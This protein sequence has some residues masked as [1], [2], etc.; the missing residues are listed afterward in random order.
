MKGIAHTM[1]RDQTNRLWLVRSVE[2]TKAAAT[3]EIESLVLGNQILASAFGNDSTDPTQRH[4]QLRLALDR[5][6]G[7]LNWGSRFMISE[8]VLMKQ[9]A[10]FRQHWLDRIA[11]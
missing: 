8:L 6:N 4:D 5:K 1:S 11:E 9:L 3:S 10:K 7:N 2:L